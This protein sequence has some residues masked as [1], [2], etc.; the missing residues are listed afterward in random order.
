[1]KALY[2][3]AKCL[4]LNLRPLVLK[5]P[6]LSLLILLQMSLLFY[7]VE[8]TISYELKHYDYVGHYF[9]Q[10]ASPYL[11]LSLNNAAAKRVSSLD[12]AH[13][14]WEELAAQSGERPLGAFWGNPPSENP[15]VRAYEYAP[16]LFGI[17]RPVQDGRWLTPA[18]AEEHG[19]VVSA[20]L[21][22]E[23]PVGSTVSHTVTVGDY[24]YGDGWAQETYDYRV[25]GVL[26][27]GEY[28]L[29]STFQDGSASLSTLID[30]SNDRSFI[31]FPADYRYGFAGLT[32]W[33]Q[34][35]RP[36]AAMRECL[37]DYGTLYTQDELVR[38]Y[39]QARLRA[40]FWESPRMGALLV[41]SLVLMLGG[42]VMSFGR[43]RREWT[44][45][46]LLGQSQ[47]LLTGCIAVIYFSVILLAFILARLWIALSHTLSVSVAR[48][49]SV[50]VMGLAMLCTV[51]V[52][53]AFFRHSPMELFSENK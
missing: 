31:L 17:V 9:E 50:G 14:L 4:R 47:R 35:D 3:F 52:V 13:A 22:A 46:Y 7:S 44:V 25:V 6:L 15:A 21:A 18:D 40:L 26:A 38:N 29:T 41:L 45:L 39:Q 37:R 1:M 27:E 30:F 11:A 8:N 34:T 12:G 5:N 48:E 42:M 19:C 28:P 33:F 23:Y 24:T 51:G 2:R 53:A 49:V 20:D 10:T 43:H 36:A 16:E 32:V